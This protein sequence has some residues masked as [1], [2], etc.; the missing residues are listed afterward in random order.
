M[1]IYRNL[2]LSG[3]NLSGI[4]LLEKKRMQFSREQTGV[5]SVYLSKA[6]ALNFFLNS[7]H[8][9]QQYFR[10]YTTVQSP[11]PISI[12]INKCELDK[13]IDS[14]ITFMF[15][16]CDCPKSHNVHGGLI[17]TAGLFHS[18]IAALTSEKKG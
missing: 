18:N 4:N 5:L 9:D 13:I 2:T 12:P 7:H 8:N 11:P 15:P 6:T 3:I 1:R 10:T 14:F 17:E 16:I